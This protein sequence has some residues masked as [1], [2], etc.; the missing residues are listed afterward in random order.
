MALPIEAIIDRRWARRLRRFAGG[1]TVRY[2][3]NDRR[4]RL[5]DGTRA[6][7]VSGREARF[8]RRTFEAVDRITGLRLV[9]KPGPRRTEIDLYRVPDFDRRGLLGQT[10]LSSGWFEVAWENRGGNRLTR[11]ERWTITHEI[12]HAL[13]LDHPYGRPFSPRFTSSDTVMSYNRS[14][15]TGFTATDVAALQDLWGMA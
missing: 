5:L 1:T 3:I 14:A 7:P 6:E 13:G 9:E 8:I 10:T 15:N 4:G 11:S 2:W 12:G